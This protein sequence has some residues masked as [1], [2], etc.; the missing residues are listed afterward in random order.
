MPWKASSI[1]SE[2]EEFVICARQT[3]ANISDLSRRFGISRN[4]AYRWVQ[5]YDPNDADWSR[6][7]SRRPRTIIRRTADGVITRIAALRLEHPCWGPRK[8]RRLLQDELPED[9]LPA[10]VTVARILKRSGLTAAPPERRVEQPLQRFVRSRPNELWQMDLKGPLRL[11]DGHKYYA[12]GIIDDHSRYL[13]ALQLVSD[14][15]DDRTLQVWIETAQKY[16]L[17]DETLTD[18]GSQFR[19]EDDSTSAFRAHLWA[20]GVKHPQG[21]IRHP[22]TQGKIERFWKTFTSEFLKGRSYDDLAAWQRDIDVWRNEYNELRP[23]QELGDEPPSRYYRPGDRQYVSPIRGIC[24]GRSESEYR[25]VDMRGQ[26]I[27]SGRKFHIGRGLSGWRVEVRPLGT[28]IWHVFFRYHFIKELSVT[29]HCLHG[30]EA[31][32]PTVS[33][34]RDRANNTQSVTHVMEQLSRIY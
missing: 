18:H 8:L 34:L 9:Q 33:S 30:L 6:D 21:R 1:M 11:S 15:T 7:R 10:L 29:A 5:R 19:M 17:P 24:V 16:G 22:Q 2:R 3:G 26:I 4:T 27:L 31:P 28:G 14:A 23:H 32:Q 25:R 20:C 13:L 12:V